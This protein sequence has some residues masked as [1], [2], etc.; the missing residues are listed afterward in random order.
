MGIYRSLWMFT[1]IYG[2]HGCLWVFMGVYEGLWVSGYPWVL[3]GGM[4]VY[5]Y[6][7]TLKI[8]R[9]FSF[10]NPRRFEKFKK[11]LKSHMCYKK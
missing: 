7:Q 2:C 5:G 6:I 4:I 10:Q 9:I 11:R 3:M 1:G 8:L